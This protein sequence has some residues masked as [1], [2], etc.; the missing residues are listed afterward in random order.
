MAQAKQKVV[1][2]AVKKKSKNLKVLKG[3]AYIKASFNNTI[4]TLTD[5]EGNVLAVSSP[6]QMGF[7]G[8][9]KSTP[10]AAT[11]S[12]ENV[13]SKVSKY[14][15]KEV[16]AFIKGP[17]PG[18]AAAVKGLDQAGLKVTSLVDITG[19]PFNGCRAKKARRV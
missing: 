4:I 2:K 10:F 5:A 11:K 7:K 19:I 6:G 18:R 8:S 17:G 1:K 3:R 15:L 9:R 14:G 12:A 13:V 16:D